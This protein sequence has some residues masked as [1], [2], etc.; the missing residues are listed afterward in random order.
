M[1]CNKFVY[2][3]VT[4]IFKTWGNYE[5]EFL[6][7]QRPPLTI[8]GPNPPATITMQTAFITSTGKL[9]ITTRSWS[10]AGPTEVK[11]WVQATDSD[12]QQAIDWATSKGL[13]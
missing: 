5:G 9:V 8:A 4:K 12:Y 7:I 6:R 3:N 11:V 2:K 10:D 1:P 13:L